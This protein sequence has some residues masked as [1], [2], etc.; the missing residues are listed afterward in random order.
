MLTDIVDMPQRSPTTNLFRRSWAALRNALAAHRRRAQ[1][2]QL[3]REMS[4]RDLND[5]ALGRG[6]IEHITGRLHRP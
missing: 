2:Q 1:D 6:E 4:A 3:L 5:L